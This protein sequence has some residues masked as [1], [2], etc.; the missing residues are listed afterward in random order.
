MGRSNAPQAARRPVGP[1]APPQGGWVGKQNFCV[2]QAANTNSMAG[3]PLFVLSKG[4]AAHQRAF[5]FSK[6]KTIGPRVCDPTT[7]N[8]LT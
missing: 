6:A 2:V 1:S 7:F 4:N 5:H 3:I 8:L